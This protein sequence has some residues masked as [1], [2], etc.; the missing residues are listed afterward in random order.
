MV[1]S[2][3][4]LVGLF[5]PTADHGVRAVSNPISLP[6]HCCDGRSPGFSSGPLIVPFEA[7]PFAT[8][9]LCHHSRCLLVVACCHCF[10]RRSLDHKALLHREVRSP[11]MMLPP[12]PSPMLPWALFPFKVLPSYSNAHLKSSGAIPPKRHRSG[13]VPPKRVHP[14]LAPTGVGAGQERFMSIPAVVQRLL[15]PATESAPKRRI[16]PACRRLRQ[17]AIEFFERPLMHF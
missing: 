17:P 7:F 10:Q 5:H 16:P 11:V 4:G 9:A 3:N 12:S 2:T 14:E 8:A 6:P 15:P 13:F 1:C